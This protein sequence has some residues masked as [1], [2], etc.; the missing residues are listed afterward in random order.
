MDGADEATL[1]VDGKVETMRQ[2]IVCQPP[3]P[4]A[5][6]PAGLRAVCWRR[7]LRLLPLPRVPRRPQPALRAGP[8]GPRPVQRLHPGVPQSTLIIYKYLIKRTH[9]LSEQKY[10]CLLLTF[11]MVKP[12]Y[13]Q[14]QYMII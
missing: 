4:G 12:S 14:I 10:F 8:P 1:A 7:P 11:R 2:L 13:A 5:A 3:L 6:V 9:V